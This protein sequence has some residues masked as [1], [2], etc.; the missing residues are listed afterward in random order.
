M[1][2]NKNT[3]STENI[4]LRKAAIIAG[5]GYLF[6]FIFATYAGIV[7]TGPGDSVSTSINKLANEVLFRGGIASWLI[8]LIADVVVA[9]ALYILL[10]PVNKRLSLL[11]AWFRLIYTAIAGITLLYLLIA[12][13]L[14]KGADYLTVFTADQLQAQVILFLN[15][16]WE[17][18]LIAWVFFGLHIFLLGYLIFKSGYIP[19][20]LGV[21]LIIAS[22]GYLINSF[23]NF[24]LPNIANSAEILLT[25]T[26]TPAIIAELSLTIWLLFRGWKGFDKKER[27]KIKQNNK[28]S[29]KIS[30][31]EYMRMSVGIGFIIGIN[32]GILYGVLFGNMGIGISFGVTFG[33][34]FGVVFGKYLQKKHEYKPRR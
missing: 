30:S 25:V 33:L 15:M 3:A 14:S 1:I 29:K 26:I 9:W 21:L 22:I 20:I 32:L 24:I 23:A 17:L 18:T 19:R 11:A 5:V 12:L 8:V 7:A 2:S 6:I 28:K 4:S 13:Q 16:Y 31:D 27:E 10:I 34:I